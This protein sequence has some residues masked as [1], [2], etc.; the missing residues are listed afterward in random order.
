VLAKNRATD[1]QKTVA[2][3]ALKANQTASKHSWLKPKGPV[4]L[5]FETGEVSITFS[6]RDIA[7]STS[8]EVVTSVINGRKRE[9]ATCKRSQLSIKKQTKTQRIKSQ[10]PTCQR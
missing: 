10:K 1:Q 6:V 8:S 3:A 9:K 4:C 5:R 2:Y 7:F